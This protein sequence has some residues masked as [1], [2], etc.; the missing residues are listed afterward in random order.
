[1]YDCIFFVIYILF[2]LVI[3]TRIHHCMNNSHDI[4]VLIK[5]IR[6]LLL[7]LLL[8]LLYTSMLK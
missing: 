2:A 6:I 3:S 7:S 1:M 5:L 4:K 8:L